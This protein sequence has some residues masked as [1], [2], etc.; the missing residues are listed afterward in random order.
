VINL[1][2]KIESFM[3]I[4]DILRQILNHDK[5]LLRDYV[6]RLGY[7]NFDKIEKNLVQYV[8]S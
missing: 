3:F 1:G 6:L 7:W 5:L 2:R 4:D 8:P